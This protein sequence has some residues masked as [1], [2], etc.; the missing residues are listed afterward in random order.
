MGMKKLIKWFRSHPWYEQIIMGIPAL[1]I[2]IITAWFII[3]LVLFSII[4]AID[5][6]GFRTHPQQP[7]SITQYK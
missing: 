2:A 1:I 5:Y 6:K 7:P 4:Y 3:T